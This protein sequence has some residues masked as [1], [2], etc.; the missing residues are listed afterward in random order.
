[1]HILQQLVQFFRVLAHHTS[2][3]CLL[4]Q[5]LVE[6]FLNLGF[7]IGHLCFQI[8]YVF[9]PGMHLASYLCDDLLL[10][11]QH[12]LLLICELIE[13]HFLS[14]LGSVINLKRFLGGLIDVYWELHVLASFVP[15]ILV[16]QV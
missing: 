3:P 2:L 15:Q 9:L 11:I 12:I 6:C 8:K 13:L 4:D 1:M 14:D 16:F 10:Q 7:F 5:L